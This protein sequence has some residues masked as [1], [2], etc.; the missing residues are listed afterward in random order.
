MKSARRLA[1]LILEAG[2]YASEKVS[3]HYFRL[4]DFEQALTWQTRAEWF[5]RCKER[6]R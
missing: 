1:A 3:D 2:A 4:E 6:M 5:V